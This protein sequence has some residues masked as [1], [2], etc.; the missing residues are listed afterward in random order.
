VVCITELVPVN[1]MIR[2]KAMIGRRGA[3]LVGPNWPGAD[4]AGGAGEGRDHPQQNGYP[5]HLGLVSRSGTLTYEMMQA[6]AQAGYGQSTAVGIGG[7]QS[8]ASASPMSSSSSPKT[9]RR[10]WW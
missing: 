6:L 7:I 10:S 3:R 2:A 5:G 8:L 4:V 9:P 1:D